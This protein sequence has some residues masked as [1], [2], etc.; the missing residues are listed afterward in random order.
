MSP[1][2]LKQRHEGPAHH[3]SEE[4]PPPPA[5]KSCL[6]RVKNGIARVA[7]LI[8]TGH[9]RPAVY[10]KRIRKREHDGCWFCPR[11]HRMTRSHVLLLCPG[12]RAA[13]DEAWESKTPGGIRDLLPNPRSER[14]LNTAILGADGN[15]KSSGCGGRRGNTG[16]EDGRVVDGRGRSAQGARLTDLSF[17]LVRFPTFSLKGD[18]YPHSATLRAEDFLVSRSRE[19]SLG[20]FPSPFLLS[21]LVFLVVCTLLDE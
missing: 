16:H 20:W 2:F 4:V 12:L 11:R 14:R 6:D 21:C 1:A 19:G 3:G 5:K 10:L 7:A 13:R 17:L 15:R 9:W 18:S 8:R